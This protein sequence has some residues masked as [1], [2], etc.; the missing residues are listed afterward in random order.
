[1]AYYAIEI[2]ERAGQ[3]HAISE[4]RLGRLPD[5]DTG[6]R[7]GDQRT[8]ASDSTAMCDVG[9]AVAFVS[10]ARRSGVRS[11]TPLQWGQV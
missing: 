9:A 3:R 6:L 1:M 10:G 4:L 2:G 5:R 11:S 8:G 7:R